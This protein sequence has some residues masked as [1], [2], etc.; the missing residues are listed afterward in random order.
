MATY[1]Y[2]S[3]IDEQDAW[4]SKTLEQLRAQ[5]REAYNAWRANK[6]AA[7]LRQWQW[8]IQQELLGLTDG[9]WTPNR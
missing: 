1:E 7:T 9:H 4:K 6:C 2:N 5:S 3:S 8:T